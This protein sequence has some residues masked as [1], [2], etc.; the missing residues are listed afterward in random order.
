MGEEFGNALKEID[1]IVRSVKKEL[2]RCQDLDLIG[3]SVELCCC[4]IEFLAFPFKW[5]SQNPRKRLL[6]SLNENLAERYQEP[7]KQIR[8]L[9]EL[10]KRSFDL[11]T[12]EKIQNVEQILPALKIHIQQSQ[13]YYSK[14]VRWAEELPLK[15]ERV[16]E[17]NDRFLEK[18]S[19]LLDNKLG[20]YIRPL[21]DREAQIF[22][23]D[24]RA[25]G[26]SM[27][28]SETTRSASF[29]EQ[30]PSQDRQHSTQIFKTRNEAINASKA[31]D[32]Y[33]DLDRIQIEFPDEN[34]FLEGEAVRRLQ[35]WTARKSSAILGIFGPATPSYKDPA[36]LLVSKYI[37]AVE[38]AGELCISY[39]CSTSHEAPPENRTRETVG[40][41][42]LM[43]AL[44]KQMV[45]QLPQQLPYH[46][47]LDQNRFDSLDGTLRTWSAALSLLQ[48]LIAL[49][50]PSYLMFA[51]HGIEVLE[52]ESTTP[53]LKSLLDLIQQLVDN[54]SR[55]GTKLKVLFA[56]SG[57]SQVLCEGLRDAEVCDISRGGAAH[58]PGRSGK[59][60]RRMGDINFE[61]E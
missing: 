47:E 30:E 57:R 45:G 5:Y 46:P 7:I 10:I 34:V 42:Q 21:A 54:E 41:V 29:P 22:V 33:F 6:A 49:A 16:W 51:I 12:A 55:A 24:T 2:S 23:S 15:Y 37:Q 14:Y 52:D 39:F 35:E 8:R 9:S 48:D 43:Y 4:I 53:R 56:T 17:D 13:L 18:V 60:R 50:A 38:G 19:Q 58:R 1:D 11:Q 36:R 40:L 44:L 26:S 28:R 61:E 27:D 59:G 20:A 25:I 31:W 3:W 32:M